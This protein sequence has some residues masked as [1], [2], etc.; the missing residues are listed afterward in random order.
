VLGD[1]GRQSAAWSQSGIEIDVAVNLSARSLRD[2]ELPIAIDALIGSCGLK[3]ERIILEITESAVMSDPRRARAVLGRLAGLGVRISIDDFGTGYSSLSYLR[4]LPVSELKIDKS[5][6]MGMLEDENDA[7]IVRSIVDLAHNLGLSVTAEGVESKAVLD[8][9]RGLG[10]DVAQGF[11]LA[12]AL[13]PDEFLNWLRRHR[14]SAFLDGAR[15][16][17]AGANRRAM[18][19]AATQVCADEPASQGIRDRATVASEEGW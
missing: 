12:R 18:P 15:E 14:P 1:A 13:P 11:L 5:F 10:C 19:P 17:G 7:V 2:Q 3:P 6:V 16:Q 4:K 9:L 8:R